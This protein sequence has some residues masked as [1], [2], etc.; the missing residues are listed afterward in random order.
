MT[1]L[2]IKRDG[3]KKVENETEQKLKSTEFRLLHLLAGD[4]L[5]NEFNYP[6]GILVMDKEDNGDGPIDQE[7]ANKIGVLT[8][9]DATYGPSGTKAPILRNANFNLNWNDI[10][11]EPTFQ[12]IFNKIEAV[13]QTFKRILDEAVTAKTH[14]SEVANKITKLCQTTLRELKTKKDKLEL[15]LKEA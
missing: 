4:W 3:Q 12:T 9:P 5:G 11:D 6:L 1:D 2:E 15:E 8:H 10:R 14:K 13:C 7:L